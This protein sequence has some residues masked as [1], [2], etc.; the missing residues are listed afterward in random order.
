MYFSSFEGLENAEE[1]VRRNLPADKSLNGYDLTTRNIVDKIAKKL[2][3]R[4]LDKDRKKTVRKIQRRSKAPQYTAP[5]LDEE[6]Q[7]VA[8][9]YV[10]I[11]VTRVFDEIVDEMITHV[12]ADIS[13]S[14]K[15]NCSGNIDLLSKVDVEVTVDMLQREMSNFVEEFAD[16][17]VE[18]TFGGL[19]RGK[20]FQM[21]DEDY[22]V[23]P[24]NA[25]FEEF[26]GGES[27][28]LKSLFL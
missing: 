28:Y 21:A 7:T 6:G 27:R 22:F 11:A 18:P 16:K 8:N 23:N 10:D 5:E 26:L 12:T 14:V 19:F 15:Y 2:V 17:C 20:D 3:E 13:N 25:E 1:L 9:N 24:E 4:A